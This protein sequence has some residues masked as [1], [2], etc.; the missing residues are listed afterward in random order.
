MTEWREQK[1]GLVRRAPNFSE[2]YPDRE[3]FVREVNEVQ[4]LSEAIQNGELGEPIESL[5]GAADPAF[6]EASGKS[7]NIRAL[8]H[9]LLRS[10]ELKTVSSCEGR[11]EN[12]LITVPSSRDGTISRRYARHYR[13]LISHMGGSRTYSI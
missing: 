8:G 5:R 7:F 12:L 13:S 11:I 1:M 2:L 9:E 10:S 4:V 6:L 3:A